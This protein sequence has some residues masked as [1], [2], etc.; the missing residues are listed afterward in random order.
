MKRL[1]PLLI[2]FCILHSAVRPL[3]GQAVTFL[4]DPVD[5]GEVDVCATGQTTPGPCSKTMTFVYKV[6]A[7]GTLQKPRVE[8]MGELYLDFAFSRSSC[9][10]TVTSGSRCSVAV[11]FTPRAAG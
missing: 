11:T 2:A 9:E 1:M 5:F 7:G 4:G 6:I 10:G 8:T 3:Y